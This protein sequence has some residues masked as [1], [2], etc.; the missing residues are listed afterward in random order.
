M[1]IGAPMAGKGAAGEE[2]HCP[3]ARAVVEA[4]LLYVKNTSSDTHSCY[5][6]EN[7]SFRKISL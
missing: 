6:F 3:Y 1:G 2:N 4:K 5:F 7:F